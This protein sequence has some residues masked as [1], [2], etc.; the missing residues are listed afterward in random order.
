MK[1]LSHVS[2]ML[3]IILILGFSTSLFAQAPASSA[4]DEV[5]AVT[6]KIW[7]AEI[8]KNLTEMNKYLSDDYTEFNSSYS[9]RIDGKSTNVKLSDPGVMGE[10]TVAAEML[11]PKVQVYGDVAILSYNYAGVMKDSDGKV[12]T[13]KAKS[14]RVYVNMNGSWKLV[15]A[16]FALD[17]DND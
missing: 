16:N 3:F 5:I 11:N 15:H 14:T 7:K 6:Y 9:T 2:A 17:P 8:D 12:T 1:T 4:E 13:S 10:G